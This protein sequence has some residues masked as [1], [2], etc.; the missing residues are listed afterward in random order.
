MPSVKRNSNGTVTTMMVTKQQ[1][2]LNERNRQ[3]TFRS[4][5]ANLVSSLDREIERNRNGKHST[6]KR[7]KGLTSFSMCSVLTKYFSNKLHFPQRI[8]R[9]YGT[10]DVASLM[11][12]RFLLLIYVC[13]FSIKFSIMSM[14]IFSRADCNA[15]EL[16]H[17]I[18]AVIQEFEIF[19][20]FDDS[21]LFR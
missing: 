6:R 21:P 15:V 2:Q 19:T 16:V 4:L 13:L 8:R 7:K 1:R 5:Q 10:E 18:C 17:Y 3:H 12:T 14:T 9:S 11:C 20:C